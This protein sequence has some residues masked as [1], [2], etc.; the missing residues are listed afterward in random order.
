MTRVIF[1]FIMP[2]EGITNPP[3]LST[4]EGVPAGSRGLS[5]AIPPET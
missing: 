3:L 1:P 2:G 5:E 4:P